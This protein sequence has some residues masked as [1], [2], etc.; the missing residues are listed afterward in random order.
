[1][2][3]FPLADTLA[4]L[5][6]GHQVEAVVEDEVVYLPELDRWANL[7]MHQREGGHYLVEIR[8]TASGDVTIADTCAAVGPTFE[9][10]R[11]DGLRSFCSGTFHVLLA[12][13]WGVL[14]LDQLD[15][16]VRVVNQKAWD[17]YSGP[18]T[19]RGSVGVDPLVL[20]RELVELIPLQIEQRLVD[21]RVHA[22]RLY[23]AVLNGSVTVEALVDNEADTAL[24]EVFAGAQWQLPETGFASLR[25]FIAACPRTSGPSHHTERPSCGG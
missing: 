5:L 7:W 13:L 11:E 21:S 25:W 23:L 4:D 1:M 10:A 16:E 20:P 2:K 6:T 14:E 19:L 8:A 9:A 15:H 12:A 22:V 3:V 17:V 24:A 18:C